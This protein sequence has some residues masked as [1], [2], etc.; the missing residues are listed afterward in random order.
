MHVYIVR[1]FFSLSLFLVCHFFYFVIFSS[2][3]FCLQYP[4]KTKFF[5][6]CLQRVAKQRNCAFHRQPRGMLS[7]DTLQ[8]PLATSTNA[9]DVANEDS[10]ATND[11]DMND[12][13]VSVFHWSW[14]FDHYR[15]VLCVLMSACWVLL[16]VHWFLMHIHVE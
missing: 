1:F 4:A 14:L 3:F 5:F 10:L 8:V 2:V 16:V 6:N 13:A 9:A 7:I 15:C 11:T 12:A